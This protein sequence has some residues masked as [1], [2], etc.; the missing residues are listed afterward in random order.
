MYTWIRDNLLKGLVRNEVRLD[1]WKNILCFRKICHQIDS[2]T[3]SFETITS[4][5]YVN[6]RYCDWMK[7]RSVQRMIL[8]ALNCSYYKILYNTI[9]RPFW[10]PLFWV[11]FSKIFIR[12]EKANVTT[13][14]E[15][16]KEYWIIWEI[17]KVVRLAY[18]EER[19]LWE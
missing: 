4:S 9:R 14:Y 6:N 16:N 8:M 15:L 11:V 12:I 2:Q 19:S 5:K 17:K 13:I 7:E 18:C 3:L 1:V 10:I